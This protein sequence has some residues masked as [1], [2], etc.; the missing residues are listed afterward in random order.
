VEDVWGERV[1]TLLFGLGGLFGCGEKG[2]KK[3]IFGVVFLDR[4]EIMNAR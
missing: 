4:R 2:E 3:G 1:A